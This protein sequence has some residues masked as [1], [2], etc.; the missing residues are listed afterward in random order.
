M[1]D[2]YV[3]NYL[4]AE[5]SIFEGVARILD[6]GNNMSVYNKSSSDDVADE[7]AIFNDWAAIGDDFRF[8]IEMYEQEKTTNNIKG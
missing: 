4:F 1:G 5:P 6:F 8:S 3:K 7:K 2:I